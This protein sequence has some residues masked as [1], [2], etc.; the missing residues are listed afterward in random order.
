MRTLAGL[1]LAI[2]ACMTLWSC[3]QQQAQ[4]PAAPPPAPQ[5]CNC[6]P[7]PPVA[8]IPA[9]PPAPVMTAAVHRHRHHHHY[10]ASEQIQPGDAGY[11][12]QGDESYQESYSQESGV[13]APPPP[14]VQGGRMWVDGYGRAHFW[15]RG[16]ITHSVYQANY[17]ASFEGHRMDPWHKFWAG[18]DDDRR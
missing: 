1:T 9:P 16:E 18:C 4:A 12:S 14:P 2:M 13:S 15:S 7:V 10:Y 17:N 5:A 6:Q 3:D 11:I 8:N